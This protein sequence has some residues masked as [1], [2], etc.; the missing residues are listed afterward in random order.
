M[1]PEMKLKVITIG[2]DEHD[3]ESPPDIKAEDFIKDLIAA[4]G[5]P[6]RDADYNPIVWR[7]DDK[8][9]SKTLEGDKTLEEN[10]VRDSHTLILL[11][12]TVAGSN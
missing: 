10:G 2:G 11:R 9:I 12:A 8:N 7:I 5:L 1:T 3:I 4:L 6:V